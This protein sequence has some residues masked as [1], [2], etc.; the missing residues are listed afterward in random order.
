MATLASKKVTAFHSSEFFQR[1]SHQSEKSPYHGWTHEELALFQAQLLG[2][3]QWRGVKP[4][5]AAVDVRQW[6]SASHD[7]RA[8]TSGAKLHVQP[9]L[10]G[11]G[12]TWLDDDQYSD[13][14]AYFPA[15]TR[16]LVH[17]GTVAKADV[18]IRVTMDHNDA[19][20][21]LAG[22]I[23]R[24]DQALN[25][26]SPLRNIGDISWRDDALVPGIQA[27]D[28][29]AHVSRSILENT[30]ATSFYD[31]ARAV[32]DGKNWQEMLIVD[33]QSLAHDYRKLMSIIEQQ[34][35]RSLR[36]ASN[37]DEDREA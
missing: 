14:K 36:P 24:Q 26:S 32:F 29:L 5:G 21:T 17:A 25:E 19:Y 3:I 11:G 34:I 18:R 13:A 1:R 2:I 20:S 31:A 6:R 22:L 10:G 35:G 28:M 30:A 37:A 4:V 27:A 7:L 8:F 23:V 12:R 33:G 15:F 9:R 16:M